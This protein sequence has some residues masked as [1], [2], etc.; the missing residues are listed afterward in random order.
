MGNKLEA[1][2]YPAR[3]G[4]TAS[5]KSWT[6]NTFTTTGISKARSTE[7]K[8]KIEQKHQTIIQRR[9]SGQF[10]LST[11]HVDEFESR[12]SFQVPSSPFGAVEST[13]MSML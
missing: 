11:Q 8:K 6:K 13:Q 5:A 12:F 1:P 3:T 10:C 7:S 2:C 9:K 4:P